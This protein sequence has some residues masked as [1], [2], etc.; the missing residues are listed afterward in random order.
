MGQKIRDICMEVQISIIYWKV[1]RFGNI[2]SNSHLSTIDW[3]QTVATSHCLGMVPSWPIV[4]I[5]ITCMATVGLEF[6]IFALNWFPETTLRIPLNTIILGFLLPWLFANDTRSLIK[7]VFSITFFHI[8]LL[9]KL[10][11]KPFIF[12]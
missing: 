3:S 2:G 8:C 4:P 6:E 10:Y 1:G 12:L 7:I 9:F 11:S 5:Y